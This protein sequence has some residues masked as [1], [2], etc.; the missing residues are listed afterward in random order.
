MTAAINT[1]FF[2]MGK[3]DSLLFALLVESS[4]NP[5]KTETLQSQFFFRNG[6]IA[7]FSDFQFFNPLQTP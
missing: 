6:P 7:I 5:W 4:Y 3:I 2:F 1:S